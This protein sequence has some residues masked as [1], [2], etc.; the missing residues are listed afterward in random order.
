MLRPKSHLW[1]FY[2]IKT[3]ANAIGSDL[4][5]PQIYVQQDEEKKKKKHSIQ[6]DHEIHLNDQ[7]NEWKRTNSIKSISFDPCAVSHISPIVSISV[8]NAFK[9]Y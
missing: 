3:A 1:P 8:E 2:F 6:S 4:L 7:P 9:N 5:M